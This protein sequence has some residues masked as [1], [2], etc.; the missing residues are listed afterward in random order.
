MPNRHI[1]LFQ[2]ETI[3]SIV[4]RKISLYIHYDTADTRLT[5]H[6]LQEYRRMCGCGTETLALRRVERHRYFVGHKTVVV[7]RSTKIVFSYRFHITADTKRHSPF[8]VEKQKT[9]SCRVFKSLVYML[10]HHGHISNMIGVRRI[11]RHYHCAVWYRIGRLCNGS[12]SSQQS[13][14]QNSLFHFRQSRLV[15]VY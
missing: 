1:C 13:K 14:A 15:Y 7:N 5:R 2:F 8:L 4:A 3:A 11:S 12:Y 6:K 9:G 10:I